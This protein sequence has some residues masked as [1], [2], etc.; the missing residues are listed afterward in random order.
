MFSS[1]V[2]IPSHLCIILSIVPNRHLNSTHFWYRYV[3][4]VLIVW[5]S[6]SGVWDTKPAHTESMLTAGK[7]CA[8]L[9]AKRLLA[10]YGSASAVLDQPCHSILFHTSISHKGDVELHQAWAAL[11]KKQLKGKNPEDLIWHTPEG[12]A[13]KPIYTQAD[14]AGISD[15][16]PGVFPYSR[17]PYPTMYTYR[18]WT[19]R[20]Y[21]GFSTVEE[22]NKFYRDNIKG[23]SIEWNKPLGTSAHSNLIPLNQARLLTHWRVTVTILCLNIT[24]NLLL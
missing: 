22:S 2:W 14:T 12:I 18:P 3:T 19:I 1:L 13:I 16:L 11:A 6:S 21:A 20:Q 8:S 5:H 4:H 9:A 23:I 17:G 7:A 15:E 10:V 24:R